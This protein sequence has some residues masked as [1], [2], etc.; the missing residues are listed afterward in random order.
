MS[1]LSTKEIAQTNLLS[2]TWKNNLRPSFP[3]LAF[4]HELFAAKGES[5]PYWYLRRTHWGRP[6]KYTQSMDDFTRHVNATLVNFCECEANLKMLKFELYIGIYYNNY[7]SGLVD[8]WIKLALEN[9]V[10][11]LELGFW[12]FERG[13]YPL[14]ETIFFATSLTRLSLRRCKLN[15]PNPNNAAA[16]FNFQSLEILTLMEVCL[17][18]LMI[19]KLTSDSPMLNYIAIW[20]CKGFKH[21]HLAKLERLKTL[22]INLRLTFPLGQVLNSI[23][24]EEAP[25]LEYCT[26]DCTNM[27]G[28]SSISSLFNCNRMRELSLS[29]NLITDQVFDSLFSKIFPLLEEFKLEN[30]NILRRINISSQ[31]LKQLKIHNCQGL[32]AIHI[33]TPNLHGFLYSGNLV[34]IASI[35]APCPGK[36]TA[37]MER[38]VNT[39]WYLN[40]KKLLMGNSKHEELLTS[41]ILLREHSYNSYEF[42]QSS[43]S[44]PCEIQK[45]TLGVFKIPESEYGAVLDAH[46]SICYPKTLCLF[47]NGARVHGVNGVQVQRA[48]GFCMFLYQILSRREAYRCDCSY[49][50]CWRHYLKR[51]TRITIIKS[52]SP[53]EEVLVLEGDALMNAGPDHL[54]GKIVYFDL[55]WCF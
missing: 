22:V 13:L 7:W 36:F 26:I 54:K 55:E 51:M 3:V 8:K 28:P 35:K 29:G 16:P 37:I 53:R 18:E 47:I 1:Y 11:D 46:L 52:Q 38:R 12:L 49:V 4:N 34:P 17:D 10:G 43:P 25:N 5:E 15:H 42:R 40:L 48:D 20:D 6:E 41:R 14:P 45:L 39:L 9:H 21:C 19:H 44:P 33:D 50:H 24:V 30:S 31:R 32:E 23:E 27:V 2:K